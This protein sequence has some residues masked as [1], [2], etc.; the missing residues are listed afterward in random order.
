MFVDGYPIQHPDIFDYSLWV[1]DFDRILSIMPNSDTTQQEAVTRMIGLQRRLQNTCH[2]DL[3]KI[4]QLHAYLDELD[5]RRSTDWRSLF[6]H[7][8]V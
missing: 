5:R 7:L 2:Q 1:D 3:D 6:P 4:S 8:I